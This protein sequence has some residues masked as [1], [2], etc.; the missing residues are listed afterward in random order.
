MSP[1]LFAVLCGNNYGHWR[2][3][4]RCFLRVKYIIESTGSTAS[5]LLPGLC[6]VNVN[7][8]SIGVTRE[9]LQL[10]HTDG[11][12]T[13][14]HSSLTKVNNFWETRFA[15]LKHD[16]QTDHESVRRSLFITYCR[17]ATH[18]NDATSILMA[19]QEVLAT[20]NRPI[21]LRFLPRSWIT[22]YLRSGVC[23]WRYLLL[24]SI[25][26]DEGL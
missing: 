9:V 4:L 19:V 6:P 1:T 20:A 2:K 8:A 11:W 23:F 14:Q 10:A 15:I 17:C 18:F 13:I 5:F 26:T 24:A 12:L 3:L 21:T 22:T 25:L 7:S 16:C